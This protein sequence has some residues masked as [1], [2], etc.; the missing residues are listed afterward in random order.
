MGNCI[1]F[2]MSEIYA[3]GQAIKIYI[4]LIDKLIHNLDDVP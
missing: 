3:T 4:A 1:P 2:F